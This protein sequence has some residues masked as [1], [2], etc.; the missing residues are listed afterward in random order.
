MVEGQLG[1]GEEVVSLHVFGLEGDGGEAVVDAGVVGEEFEAGHG[2]IGE[3][4]WVLGGFLEGV[5]VEGFGGAVV[6]GL[7]LSDALCEFDAFWRGAEEI[8]R[9]GGRLTDFL[10]P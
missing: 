8:K 6:A 3:E 7:E 5:G 10:L 4:F 9:E 1:L 2:A